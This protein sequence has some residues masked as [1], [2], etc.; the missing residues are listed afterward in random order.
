M[1]TSGGKQIHT[2]TSSGSLSPITPITASY[3]V[4]AGG[5]SGGTVHAGGGG[6][7]GL[8]TSS[9]I[10]YSGATYIVTVGAGGASQTSEDS[11]GFAGSN[12][13]LS[14]TGLTTITATG[15]GLGGNSFPGANG[16]TGGSGG[17][18]GRAGTGGAATSGQGNNGGNGGGAGTTGGGGGGGAGA[19]GSNGGAQDGGAGGVGFSS[20]IS[21]TSTT[22]A[23]GGGGGIYT[24]NTGSAGAGGNGGG[25]AG[26]KGATSLYGN[27]GTQNT[28]GGGGGGGDRSGAGGSGI[29]IISYAGSQVFNGGLVTS[30]GG[31][32]IHTFNATGALTPLTNNLTN[33]LRFRGSNSYLNRTP[34][35][36]GNRQ[37]WTWSAW[38][39]RG[40]LVKT[41][42]WRVFS[43]RNAS[44]YT[45]LS[46]RGTGS[47]TPN[48][49]Y[50]EDSATSMDIKTTQVF[51]DPSAWYH[52]VIAVDTTQATAANR[53]KIY[54]NGSQVTAFS[55]ATY[56]TLNANTWMNNTVPHGIGIDIYETNQYF[57]G[58]MT[59]INFIDGQQLEPYYFGNNDANGV[60]KP[61]QYKGTYG[62]NGFY[63]NFADTS[64]L[65]T[66]SNA[67]LGKDT[68]G[69]GNYYATNNVSITAGV[70]YDAMLD[71]PT[72]TSANVA[73]YCV[74][75]P[76]AKRRTV[77]EVATFSEANLKA[78]FPSA[79]GNATFA[80][81]T[82]GV[83]SGKWY[84]EIPVVTRTTE[85]VIGIG[86]TGTLDETNGGAGYQATNGAISGF[87]SNPP[88]GASYTS[89]DIIG[90]ALDVD[91]GTCAFYKNN[92]L[93][94]TGTGLLS[95]PQP[96]VQGNTSDVINANFGQRPFSYTPP[97]GF[98]ALNTFNLP[99][100]T[101]LQGNKYMDASLY[102][103]DG[104]SSLTV[105]NQTQ[106]KPD[107]VWVKIRSGSGQHVLT[108]SVR[109]VSKQVFSS[110]TNAETTE[111]GKG[112]TSFNS[113]GFTL[114]NELLTTGTTNVNAATYVGWQW[115]AGQGTTT[116]N[117]SGATSSNVSV[118]STAG[119][120]VVTYTGTGANT[121]IGHGL[122]SAPSMIIVKNRGSAV[123][124]AA[125]H[126]SIANTQYLVLNTTAAAA[127]GATWW[128]STTP[129]SSVI[130]VGTS[131]STNASGNTYVAYCWAEI[132]G[133][134]KFGIFTGNGSTDGPF[135]YLGFRPKFVMVK[136]TQDGE[137]GLHDTTRDPYN[138]VSKVILGES[139]DAEV[140]GLTLYDFTSNGFKLRNSNANRNASG[141]TYIYMAFAEN[142]FKNSLA[143]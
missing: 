29:V 33:S 20:S 77:T 57:D 72:N 119:F 62:T 48:A 125:W 79:A 97:A 13:V 122:S 116:V 135:V 142:P 59:D 130:S 137:W 84:W 15:G 19:I 32:T 90:V 108:D 102:T 73:N 63:L 127:T 74:L 87:T 38:V 42:D 75:N 49:L 11:N 121:T 78:T 128:N 65:T 143:R 46:F 7:G 109:G 66:S 124:W 41:D 26:G 27:S 105:V 113:N 45:L 51:R 85:I 138:V 141:G 103:G 39:K 107:F 40:A 132:A 112:I 61:I 58:Y 1:T 81:G 5:G 101:I 37:K 134:S 23:G 56:P 50:L 117:T 17:G 70:T 8:L 69:N 98:V 104:S 30:S 18:G 115:Q 83:T 88:A 95:T 36:T 86:N 9:T 68:S 123:A 64:A 22:Y 94:G 89:G 14:G 43:A 133:F 60:W 92:A 4:V 100:P 54:I 111:A 99:T 120:S 140:S 106:F 93:Q 3:L 24:S 118:N 129:T 126:T 114:G 96:W 12:S 52:I 82:F 136:R 91:A 28:G 44:D 110:L 6:A 2:F 80:I 55:T 34:T 35:V 21:G 76:L 25:G 31:N 16:G 71:V 53:A 139:S 47:A 67:G 131:T 10:L